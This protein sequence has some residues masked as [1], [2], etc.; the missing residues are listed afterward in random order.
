MRESL[1]A[2]F[3][4]AVLLVDTREQNPFHFSRFAGWFSG[5]EKKA[6]KLG[7]YSVAARICRIW[8]I[9]A[10]L[11]VVGSLID[12]ELWLDFHIVYW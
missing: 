2:I 12:C 3:P 7:D 4:R 11:I 1:V 8:S 6:L 10:P 5:I 9:P